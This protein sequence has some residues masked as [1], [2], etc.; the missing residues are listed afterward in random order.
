MDVALT[1]DVIPG[2]PIPGPQVESDTHIMAM[3]LAGSIDDA[4]RAATANL[5]GWLSLDYQLTP[6][7]IA[8]VIG[9]AAEY[10]ISEVADRNAGVVVKIN[11]DRLATLTKTIAAARP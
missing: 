9:T 1:V 2:R 7:E 8:E 3:G 11:K 4:Y 6:S 10:R 5:I